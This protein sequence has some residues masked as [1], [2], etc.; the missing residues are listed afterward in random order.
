MSE[1]GIKKVCD[2]TF[3]DIENNYKPIL[4]L[5]ILRISDMGS[6]S[7]TIYASGGKGRKTIVT[8]KKE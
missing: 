4:F 7:P 5:D 2:V 1:F 3:L 8:K 6:G